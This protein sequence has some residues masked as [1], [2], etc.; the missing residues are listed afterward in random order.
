MDITG[1][2][3]GVIGGVG[4]LGMVST[5]ALAISSIMLIFVLNKAYIAL[6][7]YIKKNR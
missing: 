5:A 6:D 4:I 1:L 3:N 2:I 7:V